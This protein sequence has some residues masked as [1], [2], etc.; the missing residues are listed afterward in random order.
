MSGLLG[1]IME[2][3]AVLFL[4]KENINIDTFFNFSLKMRSYTPP[5]KRTINFLICKTRAL[6]QLTTFIQN[7]IPSSLS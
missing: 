2:L 5:I 3:L 7:S 1:N 4:G 6:N